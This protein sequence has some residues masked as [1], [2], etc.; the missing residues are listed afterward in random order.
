MFPQLTLGNVV[1]L[2][3]APAWPTYESDLWSDRCTS[4]A[5]PQRHGEVISADGGLKHAL[6]E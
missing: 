2:T 6:D 1:H 5:D 4:E 3:T